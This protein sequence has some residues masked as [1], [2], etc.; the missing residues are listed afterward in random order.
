MAPSA[1]TNMGSMPDGVG[2][3]LAESDGDGV[4]D[5]VGVAVG[6]S[7]ADGEMLA[8]G[9]GVGFVA[10]AEVQPVRTSAIALIAP[11]RATW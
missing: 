1:G 2:V 3:A 5:G 7:L 9:V 11:T 8:L 10:E 6:E 4:G